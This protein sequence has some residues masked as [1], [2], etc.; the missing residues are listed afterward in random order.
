MDDNIA[1]RASKEHERYVADRDFNAKVIDE[2][3]A[4]DGVV[5]G[6]LEGA[7]LLLLTTK[8]AKTGHE[9]ITPLVYLADGD[10]Y[11]VFASA[12]GSPNHPGWYHNV[13][14]DPDVTVEVGSDKF[15]TRAK[16]INKPESVELYERQVQL[17]P[18]FDVY[19]RV[20]T[21]EIPV[22]ALSQSN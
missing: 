20:T 1:E 5:G 8:G 6:D 15:K 21:R 7:P 9:R 2:F 17:R 14:A 16:V 3:R 11:I 12:A 22:I 18:D 13:I 4:N 10:R 19:R